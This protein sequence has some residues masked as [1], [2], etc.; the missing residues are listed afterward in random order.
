VET[1]PLSPL[2]LVVQTKPATLGDIKRTISSPPRRAQGRRQLHSTE[3]RIFP[4]PCAAS[5]R[6]A[7]DERRAQPDD[8]QCYVTG[9]AIVGGSND[10]KVQFPAASPN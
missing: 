7:A 6:S 8:D 10:I 1:F 3:L 5:G 4:M 9:T 2:L